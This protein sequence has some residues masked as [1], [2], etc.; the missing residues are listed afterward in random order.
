MDV[1]A[2]QSAKA[3]TAKV[4][5]PTNSI[6]WFGDSITYNG[7]GAA[8]AYQPNGF[9]CWAQF[10]MGHP[11]YTLKNAGVAG[12]R[13]DQMLARMA[14][15]VLAYKPGWCHVL[16]GTNDVGQAVP[17]ATIQANLTTIWNTLDSAGIRVIAGTIPPRNTY[18]GTMLVD[19][20]ALNAWIRAQGRL[21]RNLIVVDYFAVLCSPSSGASYASTGDVGQAIT[22]D[23]IHPGNA[24]APRMGKALAAALTGVLPLNGNLISS[25]GDTNNVLP[26][27]RYT[28][29]TVGSGTPPTG[30]VQSVTGGPFVYSR[31][32]RSDLVPGTDLQ[33]VVPSG[34]SGNVNNANA[35]LSG[36]RFGIGDVLVG[37]LEIKR[38]A[39]DAA[40]A[41]ST[42]GFSLQL[43]A[44][45]PNTVTQD[46]AWSS[47]GSDNMPFWDMAGVFRTP[48][49]T[50]P[51]TTTQ[52][53]LQLI[54]GGGQT[55]QLGR[56][57]IYNLT[58]NG[59]AA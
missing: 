21:R 53:K 32:A 14:T 38:T 36:N 4:A 44:V 26:Y 28:A 17:L 45:G 34:S 40:A 33:I 24:G 31:V 25:E 10:F 23:G 1:V 56:A 43:V 51:A 35:L 49:L 48:P 29:G 41:L 8:T 39:V 11:F 37:L 58:R 22:P 19:T 27:N 42:S 30:W 5:R 57:G 15:D 7:Q 46:M 47:G 3:F 13:T 59:V 2:L 52:M 12:D 50:V 18:T 20:L 9:W 16:A 55:L 6:V 54:F